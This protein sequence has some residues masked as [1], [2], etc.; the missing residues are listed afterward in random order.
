MEI[1]SADDLQREA[2]LAGITMVAVIR[3]AGVSDSTFYRWKGGHTRPSL[4]VY[5]RLVAALNELREA[6]AAE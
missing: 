1:K 5:A 2:T 6:R 3:R 4:D